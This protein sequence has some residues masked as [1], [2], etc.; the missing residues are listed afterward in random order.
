MGWFMGQPVL[1]NGGH[2]DADDQGQQQ[3]NTGRHELIAK[4]RHGHQSRT[5]PSKDQKP[6]KQVIGDKG[7]KGFHGL[8]RANGDNA[9]RNMLGERDQ[10]R[11]HERRQVNGCRKS[12]QHLGHKG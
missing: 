11:D 6:G 9:I 8:R 10:M 12:Q 7:L 4:D 5:H 1:Q 2:D 3:S